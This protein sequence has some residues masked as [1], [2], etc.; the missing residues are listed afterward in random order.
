MGSGECKIANIMQENGNGSVP[1]ILSKVSLFKG[2]KVLGVIIPILLVISTLVVYSSVAKMGYAHMGTQTNAIF[3]K[4]L[5][6]ISISVLTMVGFY[7]MPARFLYRIA[8]LAYAAC[9]LF[10]LGVYFFGANTNG[11]A[12]WYDFGFSVQPSELLKV[13]TILLLARVLDQ[14]QQT[15]NKQQL[16]PSLNPWKWGK[17]H[18][19][20]QLD[21]LLNGT[22]KILLPILASVAVIVKAHNSSA[23]LVFGIGTVMLFIARAKIWEI[24]KFVL[25]IAAVGALYIGIGGGRTGTAS[26]RIS[27]FV[28]SWTAPADTTMTRTLSD[29]DHAMVAI[30]DGGL[31][32]VG[33]GQ[34]V[35]RAKI[36]HPESDYI[37]SFF[38][39]EYGI[40]MGMILVI[41]YAWIFARALTI[42]RNCR[43]LFGG[44]LVLGL[45]LMITSQ[46]I[47]HFMVSTH[48]FMETGQNLPLISHGG[49][50]MLCTAAALGII[51]SISRQA[52]N[53]TLTPPEG[54][55]GMTVEDNE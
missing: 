42:F 55:A 40:I 28:S 17:K 29:A 30:Y 47:L 37:F 20:K 6:V 39:E 50:S 1:S 33:A 44:L 14:T 15:I 24:C 52:N 34:S 32:G 26:S 12:R 53:H 21:I 4:H 5:I 2:D 31:F 11:A 35:M 13:A 46:A 27:N 41:L 9:W 38:V 48:L 8:P 18:R 54:T 49:T 45:A 7:F 10:T 36:T 3:T 25:L 51:L 22:V 19:T 43:W 23:L 16:V